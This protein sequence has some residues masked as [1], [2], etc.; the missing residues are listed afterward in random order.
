VF[1]S[2]AH[3]DENPQKE[4]ESDDEDGKIF[5][6]LVHLVSAEPRNKEYP[7]ARATGSSK[8]D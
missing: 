2:G 8:Q 3:K 6:E 5:Q 7:I 1:E 4:I